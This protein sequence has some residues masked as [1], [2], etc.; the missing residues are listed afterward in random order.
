M[1]QRYQFC[2]IDPEGDY[3]AIAGVN[4]L[5]G[6]KGIP[7]EEEI[8]HLLEDAS[9]NAI[10]CLTGMQIS[11][12]PPFFMGL[13]SQL[14]QQRARLGHPHWFI[15]DESHHLLP[16]DWKPATGLFPEHLHNMLLITV[17]P[18]LLAQSLLKRVDTVLITG[19]SARETLESFAIA[20]NVSPPE[21]DAVE[22]KPGELLIWCRRSES[23][24]IAFQGYTSKLE[25]HRHH[26]K[27]AEGELPP[28]RCFYF[29]G[30]DGQLNLRAQN[31]MIFLQL[32]EGVD[33]ATWD[34]HLRNGDY[35]EWFRESIK[36]QVLAADAKRVASLTNATPKD[37][38]QLIRE[39][40]ERDYTLPAD[41]PLPV[42]GTNRDKVR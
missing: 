24:P 34:Y 10:V 16:A 7:R 2:L 26:R 6:P 22:L 35:E 39:A 30:A 38:R 18:N 23:K 32:A 19:T 31:L 41:R 14:L 3:E 15:F 20:A 42:P 37:T 33:D 21:M 25:S 13:M 17:E 4:V 29:R 36:D 9:S 1:E 11:D 28:D 5:G 8:L 12:R 40:I 27:Y